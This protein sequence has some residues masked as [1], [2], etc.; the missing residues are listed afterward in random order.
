MIASPRRGFTRVELMLSMI[1]MLLVSGTLY[2]LLLSTQRIS[3]AQAERIA[4][5]SSLRGG[6][7]VVGNELRELSAA[8]GGGSTQ[9]DIQS[10]A[11]DAVFYRAMRGFGY[12]CQAL[13]PGLL[14]IGRAA[15]TG[16]RDPQPGR[17]SALVYAPALLGAADSGWTPMAVT[18]V[19]NSGT[20]PGA[21]GAGITLG[22]AAAVPVGALPAGTAVRI[23]EPMELASYRSDGQSWL[24]LRSLSTGEAIQPLF[25]PL[26]LEGFRLEFVDATGSSTALPA[27]V[28]NIRVTLRAVGDDGSQAPGGPVSEELTTLVGLRNAAP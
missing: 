16:F 19:S 25:G 1:M 18:S 13:G 3:R 7:L 17:D 28:R 20:C 9:N 12:S 21:A 6:A 14:R 15:F 24:G 23:Y 27:A 11:R 26:E 22:V 8:L 10:L 4:V 2:R 5:Q